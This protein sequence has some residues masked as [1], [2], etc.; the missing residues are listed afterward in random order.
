MEV[1]LQDMLECPMMSVVVL[2]R[3]SLRV[4]GNLYASFVPDVA[5]AC[6]DVCAVYWVDNCTDMK[7]K[8]QR[9]EK[10]QPLS[11]PA[12]SDFGVS[13]PVCGIVHRMIGIIV[14]CGSVS[15]TDAR[16]LRIGF[17]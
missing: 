3:E 17:T 10:H 5:V 7:I 4:I 8:G 14:S 12:R 13:E 2:N 1:L 15:S 9:N 11:P 6:D 16:R